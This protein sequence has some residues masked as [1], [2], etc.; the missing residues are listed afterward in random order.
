[1]H[2]GAFHLQNSSGAHLFLSIP[3]L[4]APSPLPWGTAVAFTLP[5][6]ALIHS[7]AKGNPWK[8]RASSLPFTLKIVLAVAHKAQSNGSL[9]HQGVC[10][11]VYLCTHLTRPVLCSLP[12][13]AH[14]RAHPASPSSPASGLRSNTSSAEK[15]PSTPAGP[16]HLRWHSLATVFLTTYFV[17]CWIS[18]AGSGSLYRKDI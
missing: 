6:Q 7:A 2:A 14:P 1:M 4:P 9:G 17:H 15:P 8:L 11:P 13:R 12:S 5:L 18:R 10:H 3:L 16:P